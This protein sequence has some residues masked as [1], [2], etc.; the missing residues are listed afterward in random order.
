MAIKD[1]DIWHADSSKTLANMFEF[2]R[3]QPDSLTTEG[4]IEHFKKNH[5]EIDWDT[6]N[7]HSS[8]IRDSIA[9]AAL[10]LDPNTGGIG[11]YLLHSRKPD[12]TTIIRPIGVYF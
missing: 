6:L 11:Q 12:S 3:Q 9:A 2:N 1:D 7:R 4:V 10:K 8:L 5:P